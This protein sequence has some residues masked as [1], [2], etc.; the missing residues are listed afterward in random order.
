MVSPNSTLPGDEK[1]QDSAYN[2]GEQA[3]LEGMA[4]GK[5]RNEVTDDS[6]SVKNAEENPDDTTGGWKSNVGR[7]PSKT[8]T[9]FTAK[10]VAFAKKRGATVGIISILGLGGGVLAGF[11]GPASLIINLMENLSI[12][13]DSSSTA[14]ERRFMKVLGYSSTGDPVCANSTRNIKCKMGRI[15][16]SAV[17]KLKN[18][19]IVAY[20]SDDAKNTNKRFGYPSKNPTGYTVELNGK[21]VNVAAKDLP[22]FLVKNPKIASKVLGTGGAI[23]LRVKAWTGKHL[24]EK[25]LSPFGV[26]KNGGLAD[27]EN[28]ASTPRERTENT[29]KKLRENIPGITK[30]DAVVDGVKGKVDKHLG[31]AKK[32]GVGYTLAVAGCI[33]VKAPG[34][35][36]AGAAAVQIAQVLP[37]ANDVILSPGS[38]L[39]ASGVDVANSFTQDDMSA[40]G[41]VLTEETPRASDGKNSSALNSPILLSALGVNK[42]RAAVSKDYTPGYSILTSPAVIAAN[43]ADKQ[44]KEAC[45]AILSPAAMY[46]ALAV[47]SAVTIAA[48]A[49]IIGG[50]IKVGASLILTEVAAQAASAVTGE[51]ARQAVTELAT[52]NK[53][54]TAQGEEFG[55]VLGVSALTFFPAGGM[56]RNIPALK[57]SQVEEYTVIQKENEAFQREMDIASL[58][59]FDTTSRYT[60]L[61][62]IIHNYTMASV[63]SGSY[64]TNFLSQLSSF[65]S[66]PFKSLTTSVGAVPSFSKE[67]C[68]YAAEFGLS[69]EDPNNTPAINAA[70]LPCVGLISNMSVETAI[71]LVEDE[72]WLDESKD[73]PDDATITDLVTSGY[74]VADTPLTD[75]IESC[76]DAAT[77][78]YL[79][80]SAGCTVNTTTK[81]PL[82]VN[83]SLSGNESCAEGT[84]VGST[85]DFADAP[86]EGVS[87]PR[88]LEAISVFLV[89]FQ[90]LQILN[91]EDDLDAGD[92]E[93]EEPVTTTSETTD[94]HQYISTYFEVFPTVR[95]PTSETK[96]VT[97]VSHAKNDYTL[98]RRATSQVYAV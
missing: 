40:I 93:V 20:Y 48:S 6:E 56:S 46:T 29:F 21:S 65:V 70:G 91:G 4:Q 55:D 98:G 71:N 83:G 96:A 59:P 26:K 52:N 81:D 72:G 64:S 18:K 51:A 1:E 84:C 95:T 49:T 12:S 54:A 22:G 31:K 42:G 7:S 89:D 15:S 58:S 3:Y 5:T 66:L 27:G 37:V 67:S 44:S 14:L 33:A 11:A 74:I 8:A 88:A 69:T 41:S 87:N 32:G 97:L 63:T 50:V 78:D 79:F 73:I 76:S 43:K 30:L 45:N 2:P 39:K 92:V 36:A 19:G 53:I 94:T 62:S 82:S 16:N 60:L 75:F 86:V 10:L 57:E 28:G 61:G 77:G 24:S 34:Y 80:N 47:D 68:G 17:N 35:I 13:N 90:T 23:N 25:F 9:K 85:D 38:K